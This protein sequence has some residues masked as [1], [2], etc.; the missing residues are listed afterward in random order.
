MS[1]G[2]NEA[3]YLDHGVSE[4]RFIQDDWE[5]Y[6]MHDPFAGLS[7]SQLAFNLGG[8]VSTGGLPPPPPVA[9]AAGSSRAAAKYL[10]AQHAEG[11]EL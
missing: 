5:L 8:E 9:V 1:I 2:L 10:C 6:Y 3:W 4:P 7:E 11:D